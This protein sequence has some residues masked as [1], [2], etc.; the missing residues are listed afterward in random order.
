MSKITRSALHDFQL[1]LNM[2]D[3]N[4]SSPAP[5]ENPWWGSCWVT[6]LL[7]H[8]WMWQ[9]IPMHWAMCCTHIDT[10]N[11]KL[12]LMAERRNRQL[13]LPASR[14]CQQPVTTVHHTGFRDQILVYNIII[15][16]SHTLV[17]S[18]NLSLKLL[19]F[20]NDLI[21]RAHKAY[22]Y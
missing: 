22:C 18:C 12:Q 1:I 8:C 21:G 13:S 4:A 14:H 6:V 3:M 15:S 16:I 7:F 5:P 10:Q 2:R 9:V 17:F 20:M 11:A 19:V